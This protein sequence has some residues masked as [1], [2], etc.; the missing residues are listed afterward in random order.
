MQTAL[1]PL[2]GVLFDYESQNKTG[3][4]LEKA[5]E[6]TV[7]RFHIEKSS[8]GR[9]KVIFS[10]DGP[11]KAYY[12]P[13]SKTRSDQ[14]LQTFAELEKTETI[15]PRKNPAY[16]YMFSPPFT[17]CSL[18]NILTEDSVVVFHDAKPLHSF[19]DKMD[20]LVKRFPGGKIWR[21]ENL[22]NKA[23]LTPL[24]KKYPGLRLEYY[25]AT[26]E[27]MY[28]GKPLTVVAADFF[29]VYEK[30]WILY[31]QEYTADFFI[32][33]TKKIYDEKAFNDNGSV[34]MNHDPVSKY[35]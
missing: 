2:S 26:Q 23:A 8:L 20:E 29:Y 35:G 22:E 17:G 34:L 27:K 12:C 21:I 16:S 32:N 15:L 7:I 6:T 33:A 24:G 14:P 1:V 11:E 13:Q 19:E 5:N 28:E 10:L 18:I 3:T 4:A 31:R 30:E 25:G 9:D